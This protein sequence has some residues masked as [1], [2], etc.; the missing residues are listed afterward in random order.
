MTEPPLLAPRYPS[1]GA[2]EGRASRATNDG[3][4]PLEPYQ[5]ISQYTLEPLLAAEA[6]RIA[7]RGRSASATSSSAS[8]RTPRGVT[9]H[10]PRTP[11]GE[12]DVCARY[13]VGCDGGASTVRK[14]LGIEL[15]GERR[16]SQL[17]QVLFRCPDLFE[18]HPD[19]QG[20]PDYHCRRRRRIRS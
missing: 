10:G 19:R 15:E 9:A 7:E 4:L 14:Q 16:R 2:G 5:L 8:P 6:E 18:Q 1:V 17:R 20:P 13:L 12:R 3:S 11:T